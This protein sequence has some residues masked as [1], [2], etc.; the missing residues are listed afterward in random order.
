[1]SMSTRP[2]HE[3]SPETLALVAARLRPACPDIPEAEFQRIVRDVARVKAKY[4]YDRFAIITRLT[5]P[6][7]NGGPGIN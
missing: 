5:A 1:M 3:I 2:D 7:H 6:P 4:N